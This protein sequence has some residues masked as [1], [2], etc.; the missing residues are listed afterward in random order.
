M[1]DK[2]LVLA[3]TLAASLKSDIIL[4]KD[5]EEHVRVT[6]RANEAA[7]LVNGLKDNFLT[8]ARSEDQLLP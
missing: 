8:A 3:E 6:A 4:S 5:R 2:L 7:E 1:N